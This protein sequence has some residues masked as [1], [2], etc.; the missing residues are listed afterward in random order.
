MKLLISYTIT[1]SKAIPDPEADFKADLAIAAGDKIL[2]WEVDLDGDG[3]NEI[4]FC[5]KS[6]H[7]K[8]KE[9]FQ[10]A[11]WDLYIANSTGAGY[12]KSIGTEEK[13]DQ[14]SIDDLALIDTDECFV[15]QITELGKKGIVAIARESPREG[16]TINIIYA[17]TIEGD[18]LKKSELAR[19]ED[20]ATPHALY[21]KYLAEGKRTVVTPTELAP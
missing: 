4:L 13:E 6:D 1:P 10:P 9:E 21:T 19:Y 8:E 7:T 16:P 18:H 17:Y 5:L 3:K 11:P 2:K 20:S 15:G 14:I 12:T